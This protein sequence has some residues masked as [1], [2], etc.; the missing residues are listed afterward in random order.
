V[1]PKLH[2]KRLLKKPFILPLFYE[3]GPET[4]SLELWTDQIK[5]EA[6]GVIEEV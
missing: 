3:R 5:S 6:T 2:L 1:T 4:P